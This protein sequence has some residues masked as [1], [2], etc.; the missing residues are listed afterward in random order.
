MLNKNLKKVLM[1]CLSAAMI[2][3]FASCGKEPE[4]AK[5]S[6]W[7][8]SEE[9][10]VQLYKLNE[11]TK[12][13]I[14]GQEKRISAEFVEDKT[15]S[16]GTEVIL[17][18]KPEKDEEGNVLY[19]QYQIG[20]EVFYAKP[21]FFTDDYKKV[22]PE[23]TM[24]VRTSVTVYQNT[25]DVKIAGFAKKGT[26]LNVLDFDKVNAD[27]RVNMYKVS[28]DGGEGYVFGK[29]LADNQA[30][31]D[32]VYNEN[33]VADFHHEAVYGGTELYGGNPDSLDWYPYE[34]VSIEGNQF[35]EDARAMYLG[36]GVAGLNYM[37]YVDCAKSNGCTAVVI[38]IFDDVLAFDSEAAKTYCPSGY[39]FAHDYRSFDPAEWGK[40]IQAFNDAGIYTIGRIVTFND[41]DYAY[42]HPE[43]SIDYYGTDWASAFSRGVWEYKVSLAVEA[44]EK[45]GLK[46]I[47]FDYVR[48][49]EASYR[50]SASGVADFRNYYN[51][52]K[53]EAIQNFVIYAA[54]MLHRAGAYMSV[55]V[56]G[57]CSYGYVTA[58]GQYWPAISNIADA[59]S[60]MPYT[61]HF[62]NDPYLWQHPYYTLYNWAK[63]AAELQKYTPT[64]A[65]A[66]TWVT[67]YNTPAKYD[68]DV[69]TYYGAEAIAD[70]V[71]GL[72]DAGL[73]GGFMTWN[74]AS[75]LAKYQDFSWAWSHDYSTTSGRILY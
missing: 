10:E 18:D 32:A 50:M 30:D 36:V 22:V 4:P 25:E 20:E 56:F 65:C 42:D 69:I 9:Y 53:C 68:C 35:C 58:Y 43:N 3:T 16:R 24:Y 59:I 2:A 45:F 60:A 21:G 70:Q 74:Y 75:P 5:T 12:K 57:E 49:P 46:E 1:I 14:F 55:D 52:E 62:E 47:Q 29:Y 23:T 44:V 13:N 34:R 37:E 17:V 28:Y 67:A 66:R 64:P 27:G 7:L 73:R 72:W 15:V 33:G 38:D 63:N 48:F 41:P 40:M 26:K 6:G 51:E 31:A 19:E 71:Q 61:D 8:A 11:E 39:N 54:D